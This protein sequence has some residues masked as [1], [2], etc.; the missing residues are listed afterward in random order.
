MP[1]TENSS[2]MTG[3]ERV[4]AAMQG[5]DHDRV[6]RHESLW[7]DTLERWNQQGT[8]S[9]DQQAA[10]DL[11]GSDFQILCSCWPTPFAKEEVI[12]RDDQTYTARDMHGKTIRSW[13]HRAGTPEHIGFGCTSRDDW[14]STYKPLLLRDGVR[15]TLASAEEQ[16]QIIPTR[17]WQLAQATGRWAYL[18]GIE[19]F[20]ATRALL[21]DETTMIAMVEDPE[22]IR[23]ISET[24]A[25]LVLESNRRIMEAGVRPDGFWIYG[26]MAYNH[27]TMCSPAMYREL[28]WPAHKR[29]CQWAHDHDLKFIYHTDSDVRGVMD[30][31]VEA[32]FD[33]LQ[34]L[35]AKANM[36]IRTLA[37]TYGDRLTLFGNIDVMIMGAN[38][39]D[40]LEHEVRTKLA[41]G[42]ATRRYIYHSDHSVPPSCDFPTWQFVIE[43]LDRYGNYA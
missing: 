42:M 13:L 4:N 6:P 38:D 43:L 22:W 21:G 25:D 11:L 31:Y 16:W 37:P 35:E 33:A 5:R 15:N 28:I 30:L 27:A 26:D 19:G 18:A 17:Q 1:A 12:S 10:L 23:D 32:G 20:E 36:D 34:P 29:L 14:E 3:R 39:L 8:F 2:S 9:G 40:K 41:A 7:R 24:Y